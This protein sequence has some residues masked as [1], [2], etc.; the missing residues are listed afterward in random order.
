MGIEHG[1]DG[2]RIHV[3]MDAVGGQQEDIA[4]LDGEG[5][6]VDLHMRTHAQRPAQIAVPA[7][8]RDAVV[9][10]QLL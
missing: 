8:H 10:G 7:G 4:F 1:F 5:L 9:F 6:V 3:F 2:G